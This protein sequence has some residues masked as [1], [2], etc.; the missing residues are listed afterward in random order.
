[1]DV[2]LTCSDP[3]PPQPAAP[4]RGRDPRPGAPFAA[5]RTALRRGVVPEAG[6]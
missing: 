5:S 3:E 4:A 1:M 6:A 2:P